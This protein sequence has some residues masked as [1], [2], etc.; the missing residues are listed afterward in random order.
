MKLF[1]LLGL[2]T[3][4]FLASCKDSKESSTLR[5][6]TIRELTEADLANVEKFSKKF[7]RDA[8]EGNADEIARA[9]N[10]RGYFLR[11][12]DGIEFPPSEFEEFMGG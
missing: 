10:P 2:A 5:G 12:L 9:F 4:V 7:A 11:A 3:V 6:E 1:Q 8:K